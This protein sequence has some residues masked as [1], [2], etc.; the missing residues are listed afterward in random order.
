MNLIFFIISENTLFF[1]DI[2]TDIR[3]TNRGNSAIIYALKFVLIGG[4]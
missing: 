2:L 1:S 4:T 3:F